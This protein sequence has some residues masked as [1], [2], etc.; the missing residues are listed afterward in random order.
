MTPRATD[1]TLA[2]LVVLGFGTGVLSLFSGRDG[3]AWV[4]AA[5]GGAGAGLG[6]VAGWKLRR[7]W[8]RLVS[9]RA[10]DGHTYAGAAATLLVAAT[11]LSGWAWSAGGDLYLAGWNL[12]NWHIALGLALSLAV[13]AHAGVRARRIRPRDLRGRRQFLHAAGVSA[14]ALLA[15]RLQRPA[16]AALG[17]DGAARRWTGSYERGSYDGNAFPVTSWVADSPRALPADMYR[18]A[19]SGFVVRPLD[20]SLA[21]LAGGDELEATRDCTDGFY[22]TQRWWGGRL[23]RLLDA[24]GVAERATHALVVSHTGYRWSFPLEEARSF[25]LATRVGEE[26]LSHGHGAPVRLVAPQRRGFQWVKWVVRVELLDGPDLGAAASTLWS[27]ATP[28]GRG[29]R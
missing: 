5:H 28:E 6:L 7:V 17:L 19:V 20:L 8:R 16:A 9:P 25:L 29:E 1:W 14:T 4:F 27:S 24:A 22:S 15:V 26:P 23:G 21:A 18:L 10:G 13:V 3:D 2:L 12:L 11:L